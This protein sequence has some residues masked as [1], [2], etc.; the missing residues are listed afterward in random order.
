[1][2]EKVKDTHLICGHGEVILAPVRNLGVNYSCSHR[3]V[4]IQ[5]S[6]MICRLILIKHGE[7][8][9]TGINLNWH[10]ELK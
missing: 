1:M 3:E 7:I 5:F 4:P 9:H 6:V 10:R 8:F 2:I